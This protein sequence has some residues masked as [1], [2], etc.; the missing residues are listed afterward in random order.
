MLAIALSG[1]EL[2]FINWDSSGDEVQLVACQVLPW[3]EEVNGFQHVA[4]IREVIQRVLGEV[5]V[6]EN[7][8]VYVTLDASFC[9]YSV[10]EVDAAWDVAEQL[11]FVRETRLGETPLFDSFQYP[12]DPLSGRYF[13][14]DCPVV[15]RRTINAALPKRDF[16]EHILSIGLFSA[17]NYA[18]RVVPGLDRGGR[19]FWRVSASGNDELLEIQQGQFQ[20]IHLIEREGDSVRHIHTVGDSQL[21]GSITSFIELASA[22]EDAQLP[23]IET[24]FAY[25]GAG[26]GQFLEKIFAVEQSTLSLLNPFWRWNWPEVPEADNRFTQSAFAELA[27]AIWATQRV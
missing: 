7:T 17:Y 6:E 16:G 18:K 13:N 25:L 19:L 5:K 14:I 12:L 8:P 3:D 24:V 4:R 26:D 10:V 23:E 27:D 9:H 2:R 20:A 15:L 21:Q 22:G 11:S 1:R